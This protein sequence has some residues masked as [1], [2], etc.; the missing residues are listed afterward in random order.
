VHLFHIFC[1]VG[2]VPKKRDWLICEFSF[3]ANAEGVP[4]FAPADPLFA[5]RRTFY[6]LHLDFVTFLAKIPKPLPT[7]SFTPAKLK[8]PTQFGIL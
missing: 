5:V 8:Q 7:T 6:T 4:S 1:D 2:R 3:G